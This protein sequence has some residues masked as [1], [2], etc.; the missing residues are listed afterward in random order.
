MKYIS[1][2]GS[3]GSIG[4]TALQIV[5]WLKGK[6]KVVALACEKNWAIMAEQVVE[7]LPD[8][9]V[10][11][12]KKS[13]DEFS[14]VI[15]GDFRLL[16]GEEGIIEASVLPEVD[17]VISAIVGFAGLRPTL[18]MV[19]NGKTVA[20]AN[21]ETLIMAGDYFM[22]MAKKMGSTIIPVDSEHSAIFQCLHGRDKSEIAKI[23]LTASGG[24][25]LERDSKTFNNVL[26]EEAL[27]HP[28][29]R[30]GKKITV[31][32]ATL[33]NK[34]LEI[35]E[36]H[37]LFDMPY[38]KIDI[39]IHPQSV[40]HSLVQL[41]DGSF[42]SQLAPPDM[43]IPIQYAMTYPERFE[44]R[45]PPV[46][47]YEF[48]DIE[49]RK[50]DKDKFPCLELAINAGKMGGVSPTVVSVADEIAVE[51]FLSRKINFVDIPVIL[52]KAMDN[53]GNQ[54]LNDINEIFRV[55][56]EVK[57]FVSGLIEGGLS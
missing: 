2:I 22:D 56:D 28:Q 16:T 32:S 40:V 30:M 38:E 36:A 45:V 9:V 15:K 24:P 47:I 5:R 55:I 41:V 27:N 42:I 19:R 54:E 29:W 37:Y 34:G 21:K 44:S 50:P 13:A 35:I 39:V 51:A 6:Y 8:V 52:E 31:D 53:F 48:D 18:E 23:I 1:I 11:K 49:F 20:L 14:E 10:I 4:R 25:F 3:T 43:A 7:F 46:D 57:L 33:F 26:P 17:L 12:N